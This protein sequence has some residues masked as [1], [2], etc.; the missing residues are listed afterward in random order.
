MSLT[1][2]LV[3]G[4]ATTSVDSFERI[5]SARA[6]EV[7]VKPGVNFAR[8]RRLYP[9]PLEIYYREGEGAPTPEN[10][11]RMRAI[12]RTEFLKALD[13][14][15]ELLTEPAAD[16]L[17][18]RASLVDLSDADEDNEDDIPARGR[19]RELIANGE[20][21]FF[22][23]LTDSL[24]GQVLARAADQDHSDAPAEPGM[25]RDNW[26]R[27]EQ[28]AARWAASFRE[29]LDENLGR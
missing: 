12:F 6:D 1:G 17:G 25:P 29:F 2:C 10:L 13:G 28:A 21:T 9:Q 27:A 3:A 14:R 23:E 20:L 15:Y 18:V 16:A 7:Y 5:Q 8:Y 11:E 4:C 26:R 22:M 24:S 19:L